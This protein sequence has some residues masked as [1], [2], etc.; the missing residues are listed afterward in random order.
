MWFAFT[1]RSTRTMVSGNFNS[2]LIAVA[3]S[4]EPDSLRYPFKQG[5]SGGVF[6]SNPSNYKEDV[7]FDAATGNYFVYQRYG[8]FASKSPIVMTADEYRDY[9]ARKQALEYWDQKT[10]SDAAAQAEGRDPGS[11]LIPQIQVNSELF[12]RV[13]GSNIIDIRPQGFAELT[14]GGR[15]QKIDNPIIPERNRNVFTFNFDQRIQM[16]VTG[17]IGEKMK[18]NVNY[19]TEATFAFENQ[20]KLEFTGQE[21]DIVKK[22]EIGNVNLPLNSSLITGAQS[23]FGVKGQFQFGKLNLTGVFSE[24]R[25]QSSSINIQGGA[26]TTEF[27]IWGDQY[28]ANRHYFLAHYFR[29]NYEDFQLN[30]PL[31]TSPVQI[32]KVEVWVTNNRQNTQNTRNI[33]AFMDL[34]ENRNGA[35]RDGQIPGPDIFSAGATN[36]PFPDNLV[37]TLDP[38]S[39]EGQFSGIRDLSQVNQVLNSAGFNEATEYVELANARRLN[40]NEFTFHP[41]LGYI[42]LNT[43]LNQDEVLAVS[44]QYTAGGRT[45]QVGEFG[46]DGVT[47][48]NNLVVKMLKSF[49]LDVRLPSWDLMMKNVYSLSAFQVGADDFRLQVLYQNDE[50]GSPVPFLPESNLRSELLLRVMDLDRLNQNNDPYPDGFFDFIPNQTIYPQNGRIFFPI[51]EPFGSHLEGLLDTDEAKERYVFNELYDSTRFVAQ[52][53]TRLNK[54]LI[55]GQFKSSSSSEIQLNAFNI[56]PGSVSVTAGGTRLVEGQDYSVDYNLGRVSI[57][58]DGILNSGVPIKVDFENNALF[59]FQTKTFM[60]I[61]A[62]YRFNENFNLGATMVNLNERPLTQK[63]NI[64]DEPISNTIIGMNGSYSQESQFLTRMVDAIPFIDTKEP[65]NFLVSGEVARIIPGTP[66]GIEIN[67]EQT[68]FLDDF[69]SSQTTIDIRNPNAWRL[70]STPSGQLNLFPEAEESSLAYG[71]NRARLAWYSIDPLFHNDE[72]RTPDNIKNDKELQ[73]TNNVREILVGE[74]FPNLE[75]DPSQPRNIATLDVSFFPKER[76]PYNYDVEPTVFSSGINSDG[77]LNNPESRWGGIM[78]DITVTNFEEQNIE[79]IQFW[80]LNPFVGVDDVPEGGDLYFN[81][82]SI[83]EDIF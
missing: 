49:F 70:A 65:S 74:V 48:P 24:Q 61:N 68:T 60:G 83:S 81:L 76:G 21:D 39:L 77:E 28:E 44:F 38:Q 6:G 59:N 40:P 64:G 54:Y 25:S 52:N 11:S 35:Y 20:V 45:F 5:E 71:F 66:R 75:L 73:S 8:R 17:S 36:G 19:D 1:G 67:G 12:N 15:F 57:L 33:V 58:N 18:V 31:I 72:A 3:D 16:N 42:S 26:T 32:T 78:R 63:V 29:D 13:F 55:K 51:L 69:E 30:A 37:N 50:T 80:V 9:I 10:Q 47:P 53:E 82:G 23:L 46:T 41:Q 62:E 14:F 27:E 4:N 79:F 7:V 2:S 56:P 22:L 43:A 34:G